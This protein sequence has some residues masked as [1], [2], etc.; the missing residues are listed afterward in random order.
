[1]ETANG[2]GG[3]T[4]VQGPAFSAGWTFYPA[5]LNGDGL[6]DMFLYNPATGD[7]YVEFADGSG[8]WTNSVKGPAFSTGWNIYSGDSANQDLPGKGGG[9]E[10]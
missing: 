4:G 3:W 10:R 8:G 1:M 7:S 9:R 2:S 5:N 6:T